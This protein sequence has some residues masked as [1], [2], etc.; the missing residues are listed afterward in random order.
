MSRSAA[1]PASSPEGTPITV[2]GNFTDP[3]SSD[4]WT[5]DWA[6]T[7]N[8]VPYTGPAGHPEFV[9]ATHVTGGTTYNPTFTFTPDDNGTYAVTLKVTDNGGLSAMSG[10]VTT[11]ATAVAPSIAL[12]GNATV[13]EAST[14]TL[15]LGA[16]TDPGHTDIFTGYDI[17][18]GDG[19]P[20]QHVT[21]GTPQTAATWSGAVQTHVYDDG[22]A[23]RSIVVSLEDQYSPFVFVAGSQSVSVQDVPPTATFVNFGSVNEGSPGFVEFLNPT[24]VSAA[25]RAAGFTYSYDFNNDGSFTDPGDIANSSSPSATVPASILSHPGDY[26]IHGRI[27]DKDGGF[28]DYRTTIQVNNVTPIVNLPSRPTVNQNTLLTQM[29]RSSIRA[30]RLGPLLSITAMG[31]ACSP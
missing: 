25:D 1:P 2:T 11:Q 29:P 3:G 19:S 8:G 5:Y 6:I 26:T 22:P 14:Y 16:I 17:N 7:D 13:N 24:D 9:G 20:L 30:P 4:T 18:W 12:S 31:R 10:T 27:I 23:S 28:T 21:L 15:N